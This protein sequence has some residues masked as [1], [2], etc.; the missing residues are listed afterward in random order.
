MRA[1]TTPR[2]DVLAILDEIEYGLTPDVP[3]YVLHLVRAC[4]QLQA[5]RDGYRQIVSD[6]RAQL[7]AKAVR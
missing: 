1:T 2:F 6:L 4:R 5:E 7:P 3:Y